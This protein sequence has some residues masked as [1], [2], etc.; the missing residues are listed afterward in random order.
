[1][2][3]KEKNKALLEGCK[4]GDFNKV[5][6]ALNFGADVNAKDNRGWTPLH[7]AS[8]WNHIE[9]AKL[10]IEVGVDV[11]ATDY[12]RW[13][14]LHWASICNS[15]EIAKL[16]LDAGADMGAKNR[17]EN[18]PLD[19]ADSDEMKALLKKYQK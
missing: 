7:F 8:Y 11:R 2:T 12:D 5:R 17:W 19:L 15:I 6:L 3:K 16:L 14:P 13:T 18:T 9:I 1:M 10:L 4:E